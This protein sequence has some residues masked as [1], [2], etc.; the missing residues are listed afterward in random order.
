MATTRT[1]IIIPNHNGAR[2]LKALIPS[3]AAQTRPPARVLLV[4][5]GSQD[6]SIELVS[7]F[8]DSMAFS[9]N[10]GFAH[11]VNRGIEAADT[12]YVAIL[13]N[14]VVLH[15]EWLAR[16]E[17]SLADPAVH[18]A[19]PLLEA[20]SAP[21]IADG[22][23]DLL[24]RSGCALRALHGAPVERAPESLPI[25]FPPMT[26]ALFRRSLFG[27]AGLLD[28]AFQSYLEDVEFG[29]RAARHGYAGRFVPQARAVH[30]GSATLGAWSARATALIAR[31]QILLLCRHYP[32]P[33]LRRWWWPILV[34]N[35][36][37]LLLAARRGQGAAAFRGKLQALRSWKQYRVP[38]SPASEKNAERLI[39]SSE[40]EIFRLVETLHPD[41]F[42]KLYFKLCPGAASL[43][44]K[45]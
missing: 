19:C 10:L 18:F 40:R 43:E 22:A 6:E 2:H 4:D 5:N 31:N 17:D 35:L 28:E 42:W 14:D 11:A 26:A 27:E 8:A 39:E 25:S 41:R 21:G 16:L 7:G 45:R 12:E 36:L 13:N 32:A 3:I 29:L 15:P 30:T 9:A 37:Y 20:A 33:L 1:T 38:A 34:G 23:Y 24:S 44:N